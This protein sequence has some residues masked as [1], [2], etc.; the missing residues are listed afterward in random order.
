MTSQKIEE[1]TFGINGGDWASTMH[2]ASGTGRENELYES[3]S[4]RKFPGSNDSQYISTTATIF[5]VKI[6]TDD[7][8][9]RN[10]TRI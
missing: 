7:A 9:R 5:G 2:M 4:I 8:G 10:E 1:S 3:L 6:N